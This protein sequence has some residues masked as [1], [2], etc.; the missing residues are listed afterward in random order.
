MKCPHCLV[1]FHDARTSRQIGGGAPACNDIIGSWSVI[2]CHCPSCERMIVWLYC[3]PAQPVGKH[4][5]PP[6]Q[7]LV[8]PRAISR[9]PIPPDV[10]A[11][12]AQDYSE[13]CLVLADSPKASAALSR[14]CLQL[15]LLDV[16]QT[17]ERDNLA[18]QITEV[19]PS[20]PTYIRELL[21]AL[22]AIGNFAAHPLKS[23]HT[24]EIIEVEPGEAELLLDVLEMVFDFYFVQP[25]EAKKR[26]DGINAKL[27]AAGKPPMK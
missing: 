25:A 23:T 10:P 16:A 22:R 13:A 21:D 2:H 7:Y 5:Q 27:A 12:F 26:R 15:L 1:E 19:L 8:L 18:K 4:S 11:R 17:K 14:R 6:F 3:H 20:L 24:G 9:K